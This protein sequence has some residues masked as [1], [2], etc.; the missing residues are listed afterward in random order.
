VITG[1]DPTPDGLRKIARLLRRQAAWWVF[2]GL[3]FL[4][5]GIFDLSRH[6]HDPSFGYFNAAFG[7]G[8]F[9]MALLNWLRARKYVRDAEASS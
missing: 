2:F 1:R 6:P 9:G 7:L 4:S 8:W 3:V 5:I